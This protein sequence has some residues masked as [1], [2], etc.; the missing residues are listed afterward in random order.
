M[1]KIETLES[2]KIFN[3]LNEINKI[4]KIIYVFGSAGTGKSTLIKR[5]RKLDIN[6]V[7]LAPTGIA[8][9]NVNGQTI[10]SFFKFDFSPFP[11]VKKPLN[12]ALIK[13]LDLLIIDEVSMLNPAILDAIDLSLKKI[14]GTQEPFGG[15]SVMFVGDM[16]QLEP[17]VRGETKKYFINEFGSTFFFEAKCLKKIF[18]E[19]FELNHKFRHAYDSNFSNLLDSIRKGENL[20]KNLE[21]INKHC[22]NNFEESKS[23]MILTGDN[24]SADIKNEER[25]KALPPESIFFQAT[26]TGDFQYKKDKE[27]TLPAPLCLELKKGAQVRMVK[28][29]QGKWANGSL[30]NI[31]NLDKNFIEVKIG[32][33]TYEVERASWEIINYSYDEDKEQIIKE[34]KGQFHQFPMRLGWASTIHKSQGL[35]LHSC[36]IDLK[37]AFCHGQTYVALSR[38]FSLE[39]INLLHP[40]DI[41][42]VI[43]NDRVKKFHREILPNKGL[44][45]A[46]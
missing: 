45:V 40:L 2:K 35:S 21:I 37:S 3:S 41:G 8:A 28:N 43:I 5:I 38:C 17:V 33:V 24:Y 4:Q 11:K 29:S 23:Q 13:K 26:L 1:E 34:I 42:H 6:T 18:P 9:L 39:G 20:E 22:L 31:V 30:G 19:V 27:E 15:V 44:E 25:L 14:R 32:K 7:V 46:S 12:S 16:F 36:T 10:H